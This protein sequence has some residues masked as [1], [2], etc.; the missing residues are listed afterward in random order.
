MANN[1]VAYLR[2]STREQGD[3]QA[4]LDAQRRA[5]SNAGYSEAAFLVD[6]GSASHLKRDGLTEALRLLKSGEKTILVVAKLDRLSRSVVDFG[7]LM[8]L[9]NREGWSL[10]AI[11]FA[12]DTRSPAGRLVANVM[13]S[14]AAWE[15]EVIGQ[16]TKDALAEKRAQ[17]VQLGRPKQISQTLHEEIR[18]L[19]AEGLNLRQIAEALESRGVLAPNGG[20]AWHTST[21]S[22]LVNQ[23]A[24]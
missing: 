24:A 15:R 17:G 11:D 4:G 22:R 1:V 6:V 7:K 23:V 20:P 9:S 18:N 2:V 16:R 19:K 8:D 13:M 10:V 5:I 21:L 3:S 12:L 14:V